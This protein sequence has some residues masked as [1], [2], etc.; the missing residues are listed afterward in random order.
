MS[1]VPTQQ[2]AREALN[3]VRDDTCRCHRSYVQRGM[4]DPDCNC[5]TAPYVATL[6]AFIDAH[7]DQRPRVI[8]KLAGTTEPNEGSETK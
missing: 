6:L 3:E 1:S 2:Q 8:P 4:Q 5:D 7:P